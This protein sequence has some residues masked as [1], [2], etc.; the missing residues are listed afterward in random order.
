LPYIINT[1]DFDSKEDEN[2]TNSSIADTVLNL[3]P[4]SGKIAKSKFKFGNSILF[5]PK[6]D[7]DLDVRLK[8]VTDIIERKYFFDPKYYRF[9]IGS[10][11]ICTNDGTVGLMLNFNFILVD[12][13]YL[14]YLLSILQLHV[15]GLLK[16]EEVDSLFSLTSQH[17]GV[18]WRY[19]KRKRF[20]I[21]KRL[22]NNREVE[23]IVIILVDEEFSVQF[24]SS[25]DKWKTYYRTSGH[26]FD[27]KI[28]SS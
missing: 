9:D 6:I 27:S 21:I 11:I 28:D 23:S 16:K 4:K 15:L 13:R 26:K 1:N 20:H 18:K 5:D 17:L 19:A 7:M 10:R 24:E 8:I 14:Y 22:I 25:V 12:S 3:P 2:V